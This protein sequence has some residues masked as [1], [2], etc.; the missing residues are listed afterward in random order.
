MCCFF[1]PEKIPPRKKIQMLIAGYARSGKDTVADIIS[2]HTGMTA[3]S[4]SAI[5]CTKIIYPVM[6]EK[7][8]SPQECFNDRVNRRKIWYDL[9]SD[10]TKSDPSRLTREILQ[11]YDIYVGMRSQKEFEA[12]KQFFDTIIWVDADKRVPPESEDSCTLT[13][14]CANVIIKNNGTL[15]ELE[16]T[17]IE[18]L[19]SQHLY[20][21]KKRRLM[22]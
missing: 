5:A 8:S 14:D 19:K 10:Y 16:L 2:K 22:S 3:V 21:G 17:V 7:Y 9:I 20:H 4:S 12:S 15:R 13:P 11:D 1:F 18:F 6:K